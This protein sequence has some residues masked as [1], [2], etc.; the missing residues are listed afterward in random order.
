[1]NKRCVGWLEVRK[2]RVY[3][4]PGYREVILTCQATDP[5]TPLVELALRHMG[6]ERS[7]SRRRWLAANDLSGC[8]G[9]RIVCYSGWVVVQQDLEAAS[10]SWA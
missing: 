5:S 2:V 1:M 7:V 9:S 3:H 6:G 8:G 10:E 4:L